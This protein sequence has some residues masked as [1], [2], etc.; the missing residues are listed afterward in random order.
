MYSEV[1]TYNDIEALI[2]SLAGE[3]D[4]CGY[5]E[6]MDLAKPEEDRYYYGYSDTFVEVIASAYSLMDEKLSPEQVFHGVVDGLEKRCENLQTEYFQALIA[7]DGENADIA[8]KLH[9]AS[10][11]VME[12]LM[13]FSIL[14]ASSEMRSK[15]Y[16]VIHDSIS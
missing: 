12:N 7:G 3:R 5:Q 2:T 10:R 4:L 16:A 13:I 6:L 11:G 1:I 15:M 14:Y 8:L 9:K